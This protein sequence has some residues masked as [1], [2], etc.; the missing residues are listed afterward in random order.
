MIRRFLNW[1]RTFGAV[2]LSAK[3]EERASS[4]TE[5]PKPDGRDA[6]DDGTVTRG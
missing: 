5:P 3:S 4:R 2:N 1:L 6:P